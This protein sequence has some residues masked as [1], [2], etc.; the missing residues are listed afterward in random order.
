[1]DQ[2]TFTSEF[3]SDLQ[4]NVEDE[5]QVRKFRTRAQ[6]GFG[7]TRLWYYR[8]RLGFGLILNHLFLTFQIFHRICPRD[9]L[10]WLTL[11]RC[12][13][14]RQLFHLRLTHW[15]PP[16]FGTAGA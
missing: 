6:R 16:L 13:I 15:A 3:D 8:E 2:K 12:V 5:L 11:L 1:M 9:L 10:L 14:G 4:R 7:R